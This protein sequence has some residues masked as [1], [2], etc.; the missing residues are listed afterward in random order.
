MAIKDR[1]LREVRIGDYLDLVA[2]PKEIFG[3][4]FSL[5]LDSVGIQKTDGKRP[6]IA[7]ETISYFE[8]SDAET[9][10]KETLDQDI[11]QQNAPTPS[12]SKQDSPIPNAPK[13]D[14]LTL[15]VPKQAV[16]K[17]EAFTPQKDQTSSSPEK[18]NVFEKAVIDLDVDKI[19]KLLKDKELLFSLGYN[20]TTQKKMENCFTSNS[21]S[22]GES[23]Y[24]IA[25]RLEL[26]QN[27]Q[28][29]T[30]EE[31]FQR[32]SQDN[33]LS[34][35]LR[36]K[37]ARR[38]YLYCIAEEKYEKY[39]D[40]LAE[41]PEVLDLSKGK[42]LVFYLEASLATGKDLEKV[43]RNVSC[44]FAAENDYNIVYKYFSTHPNNGLAAKMTRQL[45]QKH[46]FPQASEAALK[47]A[48]AHQSAEEFERL[49]MELFVNL[50]PEIEPEQLEN[51]LEIGHEVSWPA[52]TED[53]VQ[54]IIELCSK[55]ETFG[56]IRAFV[57][58]RRRGMLSDSIQTELK[59]F[60]ENRKAQWN[61]C[62]GEND[63]TRLLYF[64]YLY[65]I[66]EVPQNMIDGK[67]RLL[68]KEE[69]PE[70]VEA[71]EEYDT[72]RLRTVLGNKKALM[73]Q[74]YTN[75]NID[76]FQRLL[77]N[78]SYPTGH[79]D[80]DIASRLYYWGFQDRAIKYYKKSRITHRW[81]SGRFPFVCC[82][83]TPCRRKILRFLKNIMSFWMKRKK[84]TR[85][86]SSLPTKY[87]TGRENSKSFMKHI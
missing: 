62:I 16:P 9:T 22:K 8:V 72:D 21:F 41:K 17:Q 60:V 64:L 43:I 36:L 47:Y 35:E 23:L 28:N 29:G 51:L 42:E 24:H 76:R 15:N 68:K 40:L 44:D 39:F 13:Q 5:D 66:C 74:G 3:Q 85:S 12:T 81:R 77:G 10:K 46:K 80:Y 48:F 1:F 58:L 82:W 25:A 27:N 19:Q 34:E 55:D 59:P 52:N 6:I 56:L 14:T 57:G 84:I 78:G 31:F 37:A 79:T 33:T 7:L 18:Y 83:T 75:K 32:A 4:V 69:P 11:P 63:R 30:A 87:C 86:T 73:L 70:L 53:D 38:V 49:R 26:F 54:E 65:E 45:T 50:Y 20:E 67:I 71:L 2:G 61:T